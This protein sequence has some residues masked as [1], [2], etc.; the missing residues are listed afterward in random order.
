M[1]T[2]T[3]LANVLRGVLPTGGTL[4]ESVWRRRHRGVL[5]LLWLHVPALFAF[6]LLR[7]ET[8]VHALAEASAV[9]VPATAALLA[10]HRRRISTVFASVG[11]VIASAVL[12]HL[13]EG[14]I[15][16]HFHFFLMVGVVVLY[17]DWCPYGIAIAFVTL[18][19]G[20]LGG[21][22]P[23]DV[24][25]HPAAIDRPWTWAVIHGLAILGMSAT[26]IVTWRLN[27]S[28]QEDLAALNADLER[29]VQERT[30]EAERA[31]EAKSEFLSRMSH[32]LRTPLHGMLGFAQLLGMD[33]LAPAQA[34]SVEHIMSGG[35]HLLGLINEVLDLACIE[36]GHLTMSI[37]PVAL[38]AVLDEALDL[39]RPQ[40]LVAGMSLPPQSPV[41]P[42]VHVWAD[43]QRLRQIVVN[44]LSNAIKYNGEAGTV[45]LTC[46]RR[47]D[48]R[49]LRVAVTDTGPGI[50][51]ED[52]EKIFMPFERLGAA[53]TPIE[54]TGLGLAVSRRLAEAMGAE[55]G[56]TSTLGEGSTFW[57]D[58]SVAESQ[59]TTAEAPVLGEQQAGSGAAEPVTALYIEDNPSNLQLVMALLNR[60]PEV[61]LL[62]ADSGHMGLQ[63]A[64]ERLP[65]LVLLDLG[66]PDVAGAEVLNTLRS[67]TATASI[68]VVIVSADATESQVRRLLAAG[69]SAYLTKPLDVE[70]FFTVVDRALQP[71]P[72]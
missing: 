42:A 43:Q 9:A 23:H 72:V 7:G 58:L 17:Q 8:A 54:G 39:L 27:E 6:A 10:H 62:T 1:A 44:L 71:T 48:G 53:D 25:N 37:E 51:T 2:F 46:E 22:A 5:V 18:H 65:D 35:R 16:A 70:L 38:S 33:D 12:L 13:A 15:E 61:R 29:Q 40:A 52:A 57:V 34:A 20:I 69:A 28:L 32:E 59:A 47:D 14:N 64:R 36:S 3:S 49:R 4:S 41:G 21:L 50:A 60:M 68:P 55:M 67:D 45:S 24:Y 11:L 63:V 26:G 19:H 66:L 31:N 56:F 30:A